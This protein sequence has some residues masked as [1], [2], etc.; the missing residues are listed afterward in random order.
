VIRW[1]KEGEKVSPAEPDP[2]SPERKEVL[3]MKHE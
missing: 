1:R 3:A 2:A